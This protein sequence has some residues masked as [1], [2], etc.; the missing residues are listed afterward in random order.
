MC[1]DT[2][3]A[4]GG[5]DIGM[6][7]RSVKSGATIAAGNYNETNLITFCSWL[8][9]FI[10]HFSNITL[11]IERRSTGA[12][13]LDY[14]LLMLSSKGIDPFKR[15]YNKVVQDAEEDKERFKEINKP[16]YSRDREIL[17]KYKKAFG[18]ATSGTGA[19]SRSEL[20]STTLI[21]AAKLTGDKVYDPMLIHQILGLVI[22]NGR[23][24][25]ADGEHDDLCIAW[26]LGMWLLTLGKNLSFYG[27]NHR[28]ILC[29]NRTIIEANDPVTLYN[30]YEQDKARYDV[31]SLMERIKS[32]RDIYIVQRLE[33]DLKLAYSKL[34]TSDQQIVSFD[35]LMAQLNEHKKT[36]FTRQQYYR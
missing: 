17:T 13:I 8:C 6:H 30:K 31:E 28:D 24:D 2:S 32:E 20:Y 36:S 5:D 14:L 10:I 3:D 7:I 16:V 19:T 29:E 26:L 9:D 15:I 25:H 4:S 11:I 35:S 18:F 27:I 12:M 23:V 22:K 34:S 21:N 1:L 33:S